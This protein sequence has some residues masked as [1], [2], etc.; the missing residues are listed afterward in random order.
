MIHRERSGQR[1]L[2]IGIGYSGILN[3]MDMRTVTLVIRWLPIKF[4]VPGLANTMKMIPMMQTI[5]SC[6]ICK[7]LPTAAVLK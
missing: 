3:Y 5:A 7:G 2:T 4:W 6:P 1:V